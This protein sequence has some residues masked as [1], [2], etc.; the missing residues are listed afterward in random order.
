MGE[1]IEVVRA[2]L[3]LDNC[4]GAS[5]EFSYILISANILTGR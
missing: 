5:G 3:R 2:G 4:Q 1:E